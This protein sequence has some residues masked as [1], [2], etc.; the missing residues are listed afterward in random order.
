MDAAFFDAVRKTVFGGSLSQP[1]VDGINII[2][3]A[4]SRYGDGDN[5]KLAYLLGTAFH[6]TAR[7]MQPV[8]ETLA[9][10]DAKAKE[11]L[12]KAWRAGKL[13]WV[14]KDYWS[15]GWFGRGYVQLTHKTNYERAGRELGVDLVANPSLAMDPDIAAA[16]LIKGCMEGWFTNKKLGTYITKSDAD[17]IGARRVVNG[18][19]KAA[20]IAGYATSFYRALEVAKPVSP[21]APETPAS[22]APKPG[23]WVSALVAFIASII[24]SFLRKK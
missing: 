2:A 19:D 18:T 12:T 11:R 21:P 5:R 6:E 16:I 20:M 15:S 22:E 13:P 24:R 17:Y 9:T 3:D 1:Q 7:T 10:T 23:N 4:W 8:R 14:S